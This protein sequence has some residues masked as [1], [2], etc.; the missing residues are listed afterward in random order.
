MLGRGSYKRPS[1]KPNTSTEALAHEHEG[2]IEVVV[3]A[4]LTGPNDC[5]LRWGGTASQ[6]MCNLILSQSKSTEASALKKQN[7]ESMYLPVLHSSHVQNATCTNALLNMQ[8]SVSGVFVCAL[9]EF[10]KT[11]QAVIL[12]LTSEYLTH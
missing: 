4:K 12:E 7:K 3:L 9:R 2:F 6:V 8:A 5:R 11:S 1:W 10:T